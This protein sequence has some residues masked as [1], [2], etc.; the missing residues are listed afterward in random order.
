MIKLK[1]KRIV[2]NIERKFTKLMKSNK[3]AIKKQFD[4][5]SSTKCYVEQGHAFHVPMR[6]NEFPY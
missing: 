2:E 3:K 6:T 1:D 5:A 4:K